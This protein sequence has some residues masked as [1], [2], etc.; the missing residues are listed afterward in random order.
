MIKC[1]CGKCNISTLY[2]YWASF[3]NCNYSYYETDYNFSIMY[4]SNNF[5]FFESNSNILKLFSF[6]EIVGF[7]LICSIEIKEKITNIED[8]IIFLSNISNNL[9]FL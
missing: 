2:S 5:L 3:C 7:E 6:R 4:R 9:E 1:E 8:S